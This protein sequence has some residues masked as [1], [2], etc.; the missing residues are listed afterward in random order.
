MFKREMFNFYPPPPIHTF[1]AI[2]RIKVILKNIKIIS[3]YQGIAPKVQKNIEAIEIYMFT[4]PVGE[5]FDTVTPFVNIDPFSAVL[6]VY[7]EKSL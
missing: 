2:V 5:K 3:I 7:A 1:L 6:S 4:N